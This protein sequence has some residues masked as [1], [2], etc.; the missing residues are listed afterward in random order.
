LLKGYAYGSGLWLAVSLAV[1][2][3]APAIAR[4]GD[5][6][7]TLAPLPADRAAIAA[8]AR[9]AAEKE[10]G[11]PLKL[12]IRSLRTRDGWAFLFSN[13]VDGRGEPLSLQGTRFAGAATEGQASRVYCALLQRRGDR[14]RIVASCIAVTDVAWTNWAEKYGAPPAIFD[15]KD[16]D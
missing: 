8:I 7:T 4:V 15:L 2:A 1:M 3:T 9:K 13:M 6:A 5:A 11:K 10:I 14:W 12:D 16:I